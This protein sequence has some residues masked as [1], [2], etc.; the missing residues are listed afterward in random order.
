MKATLFT[1]A[2]IALLGSSQAFDIQNKLAQVS[3]AKAA[4]APVGNPYVPIALYGSS[5]TITP[6][7][8]VYEDTCCYQYM[9]YAPAT[10][11]WSW[12]N[13]AA[14]SIANNSANTET[15]TDGKGNSWVFGSGGNA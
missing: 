15:I 3:D 13:Y 6:T 7:S 12:T 9:T 11:S 5:F 4:A 14:V 8:Q 1:V 10:A 2:T